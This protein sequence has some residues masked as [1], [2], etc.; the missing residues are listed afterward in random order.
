[1]TSQKIVSPDNQSA[2]F[3]ELFFDLVF[4]F[5]VTQIVGL[6]H[7]GIHWGVVAQAVLV[8]WL[9]WWAW[10][11]FT[12][13]LN[14]ADTTHS[15]VQLGTLL[16][17]GVAFF[18]AVAVPDAFHGEAWWFAVPYVLLRVI[19]LSLYS[20][21]AWAD[22]SHRAA[23]KTFTA[24]STTGLAAVLVG[25]HI[26]G[27]GQYWAWGF[28]IVLDVVAAGI[29]GRL[30]GWNLHPEHFG[31]RHG[32]IVIIALGETLIVAA[33]GLTGE[34]WS[35]PLVAV[36][37]LAVTTSC[38]AWWSYFSR[39]HPSLERALVTV[40]EAGQAALARD[41]FSL[42]HFPMLCGIIA[43]A[44][45]IEEAV[46]RPGDPLSFAGRGALA[47]GI[48]LF[49]GGVAVAVWRATAHVLRARVAICVAAGAAIAA[50]GRVPAWGSLLIAF[51]AVSWIAV[52]EQRK[53][54]YP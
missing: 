54:K 13:A 37:F 22:P 1:M 2:T 24:V 35:P 42:I 19:G 12:W 27:A 4:V 5:S 8:F 7:H 23:V 18:M 11:Q 45:A 3:V 48:L 38:A 52:S 34:P 14:A 33:A 9:V 28:A 41:T 51:V 25:G 50:L 46:A 32:L 30:G 36:A 16:A 39:A 15:W 53:E 17:T 21:V 6:F 20:W 47:V 40:P 10:T 29:G 49:V 43:Y 44:V 26:G 31:E